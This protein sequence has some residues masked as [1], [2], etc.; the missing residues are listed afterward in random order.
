MKRKSKLVDARFAKGGRYRKIIHEIEKV[1]VCPFCPKHFAWHTKPILKQSG[2]W[3]ITE[4][5]NPYANAKHHF[6]IIKK[7]HREQFS[8]LGAR[9]WRALSALVRWAVKKFKIKGGGIAMRFGDT[10]YTGATVCHLHAHLIVPGAG[11]GKAKP[12]VFPIG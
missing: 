2:D 4:N 11:N 1:G 6:V 12:V 8:D 5:F 10:A 9:D 7:A 3:L